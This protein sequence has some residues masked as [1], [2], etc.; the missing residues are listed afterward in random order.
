M[1]IDFIADTNIIIYILEG[2]DFIKP[3]LDF[4]FGISIISEIELL[5]YKDLSINNEEILKIL[6][7]DCFRFNIDDKIKNNTIDLRKK[8]NIKL[9]DAVI[10]ATSLSFSLPLI[11]ADKTFSQI[12]E[13]DLIL[14]DIK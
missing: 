9:P 6:I 14:L 5:G 11:T 4:T 2:N 1:K 3:F 8:Y 7:S 12:K 10:A 13:I